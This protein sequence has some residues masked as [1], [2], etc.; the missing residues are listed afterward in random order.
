MPNRDKALNVLA[1]LEQEAEARGFKAGFEKGYTQGLQDGFLHAEKA[2]TDALQ[3]T[4]MDAYVDLLTMPTPTPPNSLPGPKAS[5]RGLRQS[6]KAI[7]LGLIQRH[8]GLTGVELVEKAKKEKTPIAERA[9]RTSLHRLRHKDGLITNRE[10]RWYAIE[11]MQP[12]L[13]FYESKE[14]QT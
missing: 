11:G 8:P 13:T 6:G 3:E 9:L 4:L 1:Q 5:A 2:A 12:A 7:V 14:H 10:G